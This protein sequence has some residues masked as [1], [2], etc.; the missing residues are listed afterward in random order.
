MHL[1]QLSQFMYKK[2]DE[3]ERALRHEAEGLTLADIT[4]EIELDT[5]PFVNRDWKHGQSLDFLLCS[6]SYS[7]YVERD[8]LILR[9]VHGIE[10]A[11]FTGQEVQK[12]YDNLSAEIVKAKQEWSDNLPF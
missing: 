12:Y 10:L 7:V 5:W 11:R 6:G 3:F 9:G 2:N 8:A 1:N 4:Q